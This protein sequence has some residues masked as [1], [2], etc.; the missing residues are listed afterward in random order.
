MSCA[1]WIGRSWTGAYIPMG[2]IHFLHFM[3]LRGSSEPYLDLEG[4]FLLL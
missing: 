2:W 1:A 3:V 4:T